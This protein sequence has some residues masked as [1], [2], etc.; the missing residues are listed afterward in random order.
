EAEARRAV[1]VPTRTCGAT[2]SMGNPSPSSV[3]RPPSIAHNG[4]TDVMRPKTP[5]AF[6]VAGVELD[7]P[8][9]VIAPRF[10]GVPLLDRDPDGWSFVW[11]PRHANEVHAGLLRGAAAL[12][13]VA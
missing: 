5:S 10:R 6:V 13:A 12:A 4:R 2:G 7:V 1:C 3:T 11:T 9:E 8:V